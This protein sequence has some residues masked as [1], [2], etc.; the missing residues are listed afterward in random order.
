M[1]R[2]TSTTGQRWGEFHS[3]YSPLVYRYAGT[4][5]VLAAHDE[6]KP[7][8]LILMDAQIAVMDGYETTR[9]SRQK[10]YTGSIIALAAKAMASD[11]E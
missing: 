5:A 4:K 3:F 9:L 1:A 10:G 6:A 11:R 7:F 8:D 2:G